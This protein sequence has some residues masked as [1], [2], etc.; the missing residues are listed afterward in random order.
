MK[1]EQLMR[2]WREVA[3]QKPP[4]VVTRDHV[5]SFLLAIEISLSGS[6]IPLD[7][8]DARMLGYAAG[9]LRTMWRQTNPEATS[10]PP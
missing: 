4:D 5:E 1:G 3:A 8:S 10:A 6:Q 2:F 7:P 9:K